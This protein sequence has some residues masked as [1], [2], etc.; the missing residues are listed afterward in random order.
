[1]RHLVRSGVIASGQEYGHGRLPFLPLDE[2]GDAFSLRVSAA[3]LWIQA[4]TKEQIRNPNVPM[5]VKQVN[6]FSP[7][8]GRD[9]GHG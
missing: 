4:T 9:D 7:L 5:I 6:V 8:S 3:R 1:V 2:G